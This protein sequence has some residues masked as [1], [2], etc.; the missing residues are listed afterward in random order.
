VKKCGIIVIFILIASDGICWWLRFTRG[1]GEVSP[2]PQGTINWQNPFI[3]DAFDYLSPPL[4]VPKGIDLRSINFDCFG[5]YY[6]PQGETIPSD[7]MSS[8]HRYNGLGVYA[9][10]SREEV[11]LSGKNKP[12]GHISTWFW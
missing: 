3:Y 2:K 7:F 8:S 6:I 5:D 12:R 9:V 10:K 4:K 11:R 1:A